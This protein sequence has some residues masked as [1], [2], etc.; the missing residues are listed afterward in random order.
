MKTGIVLLAITITLSS[1]LVTSYAQNGE[2]KK[3]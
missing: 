2:D 3:V 1:I